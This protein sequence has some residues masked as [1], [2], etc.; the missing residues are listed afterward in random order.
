MGQFK[1]KRFCEYKFNEDNYYGS[2]PKYDVNKILPGVGEEEKKGRDVDYVE[3]IISNTL[4][5]YNKDELSEINYNRVKDWLIGL[6]YNDELKDTF[7]I[8]DKVELVIRGKNWLPVQDES[9]N[10]DHYHGSL[11]KKYRTECEWVD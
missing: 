8:Y 4:S 7:S 9:E 5:Q 1:L 10:R 2:K 6:Y 3:E 11:L